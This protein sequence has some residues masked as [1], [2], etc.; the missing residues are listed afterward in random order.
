MSVYTRILL[1]LIYFSFY[2]NG[3]A[4]EITYKIKSN[5][6][7]VLKISAASL[8]AQFPELNNVDPKK[9]KLVKN[10]KAISFL[11][12][13]TN[14][15]W[16]TGNAIYFYGEKMNGEIDRELYDKPG[17][18]L[19]PYNSIYGDTSIYLLSISTSGN[20]NYYKESLHAQNQNWVNTIDYEQIDVFANQYFYGKNVNAGATL[21]EYTLG[22]GF[23]GNTWS[24]GT[25]INKGLNTDQ[26][27]TSEPLNI[28]TYVSGQSDALS[29]NPNY[30]HHLKIEYIG[31]TTQTLIDTLY[32]AYQCLRFDFSIGGSDVST[33]TQLKFSSI[34]DIS[35]QS[36]LNTVP[37]IKY[38]YK[39]ST[40]F[41]GLT[42]LKFKYQSA[43]NSNLRFTD[44]ASDSVY[45]LNAQEEYYYPLQKQNDTNYFRLE[46]S[47]T[48]NEYIL[49]S[50]KNT[51]ISTNYTVEKCTIN[52][53]DFSAEESELLIISSLALKSSAEQYKSYKQSKGVST[54]LI[55]A[56]D[57]YNSYTY[58]YHH[59]IALKRFIDDY[60]DKASKAP[61]NLFLLGKGIQSDEY[62]NPKYTKRD[63]VPSIGVPPSDALYVSSLNFNP[64]LQKMGIGRLAAENNEEV[65]NYLD[66]LKDMDMQNEI[67]LWRKNIIHTTGGRT[68][69]ENEQF[70]S[71]LKVC[72]AIAVQPSLGAKITNYNKKVNEPISENYREQ[73]IAQTNAGI[74]MLTYFGHGSN[75]FVEINFGEPDALSNKSKYPIYFLNGCSVGNCALDNSMGENYINAKNK[76]AIG[77]LASSDEGFG[78]YLR[79]YD[80]LFYQNAFQTNYGK[81][82]GEITKATLTN[83]VNPNDTLNLLHARQFIYQGDPSYRLY[84]PASADYSTYNYSLYATNKNYINNDSIQFACIIKN[85]AK[86]TSDS[87]E[88]RIDRKINN[89]NTISYP[90]LKY[91]AIYYQDT[92]YFSLEKTKELSGTNLITLTI[93]PNQKIEELNESNNSI[94]TELYLSSFDAI[95]LQ[96]Q[97]SSV[98]NQ[99]KI[100]LIV[101][102]T[103]FF[104][105]N[106][107]YKVEI[108]TS[109]TFNSAYLKSFTWIDQQ[110]LI[111]EIELGIVPN[112]NVYVRVKLKNST[113]ESDWRVS[114]FVYLPDGDLTWVQNK[115]QQLSA[116]TFENIYIEN[117]QLKFVNNDLDIS[118]N[119][120]GD[121]AR[122]DSIERR[123]RI[124]NEPPVYVGGGVTGLVLFALHPLTFKRYSYPSNYNLLANTPDY[125]FEI[126]KHSGVFLFNTN[127]ATAKDSLLHYLQSIPQGYVVSGYNG[128]NSNFKT[129]PEN[130]LQALET[131]GLSKVRTIEN[132]HPYA[133]VGYK[134]NAIGTATEVVADNAVGIPFE[135]QFIRLNY[136]HTGKWDKGKINSELIGPTNK[137]N[138]VSWEFLKESDDE[139]TVDIIGIHSDN[140]KSV[141]YSSANASDSIDLST[142][143]A[144]DIPYIQIQANF[145][146]TISYSP[147]AFKLWGAKYETSKELSILPQYNYVLTPSK[148]LQG[149]SI[150]YQFSFMNLSSKVIDTTI[151]S[152]KVINPDRSTH[153]TIIDT[154]YQF[155]ALDTIT[156]SYRLAS[157]T[158]LGLMKLE[159]AIAI[160]NEVE[161]IPFNNKIENGFEILRDE[162]APKLTVLIDGKTPMQNDLLSPRPIINISLKDENKFLLLNDSTYLELWLQRPNQ[163]NYTKVPYATNELQFQPAS[164]ANANELKVTYL[165]YFAI[166]GEYKL[167]IKTKDASNNTT[168]NSDYEIAFEVVNGSSITHFFPYPNPFTTQTQF[169]FT[170]T[171]ESI[172]EDIKIQI[173]T[174]SGK[175]VKEITKAEL[176][177]IKIGHNISDYRWNGTDEFGDRLANGVYLYRVIIKD[178]SN[179]KDRQTSADKYFQKGYGKIYLMK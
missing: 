28:Q 83:F 33:S 55:F 133:F 58:G 116:S 104:A 140:T 169:V 156:K 174:I 134:G 11:I 59:P 26:M 22:E 60:V 24:L 110:L 48:I 36:D 147:A 167:K 81:S 8:N 13:D 44:I 67:A 73:I 149:D 155:A 31:N 170:L 18:M 177:N 176:G 88:I 121:D 65:I 129:L 4:S 106:I 76:G 40:S 2:S 3:Y 14:L 135:K 141:L 29:G 160:E 52:N 39:R 94:S 145:T 37:Y 109:I 96:P 16:V 19:N 163:S 146:D 62:K 71:A 105:K 30:N 50:I 23:S 130:I 132:K 128:L 173:M 1:V 6:T 87:F 27:I 86:A 80:R 127:D 78:S 46:G 152:L 123:I 165:P 158:F 115:T 38:Q 45:L 113:E 171:G 166:D 12:A 21:S 101:Q 148:T 131:L 69:G 100:R 20:G 151:I 157:N 125:P 161:L 111:K 35:A 179:Y 178:K 7:G 41:F 114:R 68:L 119:T 66:K 168:A 172:P 61:L 154:V 53:F 126:Y 175:I 89:V 150:R 98:V 103:D 10:G 91:P 63:L 15:T 5:H 47:N 124:N 77:W 79:E 138:A 118:I 75:Y 102:C 159:S 112:T 108:D 9:F 120:R 25:S 97:N 72:E 136:T 74:S 162:R 57:L 99:S 92:I 107:E 85:E 56:E 42:H 54:Y 142:V 93:D 84:S 143:N 34:N 70:T 64:I 51:D 49:V 32:K 43:N 137:W 164:S 144:Q 95:V 90:I 82:I 122:A 139:I 17:A 153:S 117:N